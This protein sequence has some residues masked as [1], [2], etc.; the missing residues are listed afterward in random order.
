MLIFLLHLRKGIVW[1]E[2]TIG[3][4]TIPSSISKTFERLLYNQMNDYMDS[5][6]SIYQCGF[7]KKLSSQNCLLFMVE[8][9]R[10]CLDNKG[11]TGTIN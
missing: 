3:R 11:Y 10:Q 6:L 1:I 9:L 7:R 8:K 2:V 5:K 4:S